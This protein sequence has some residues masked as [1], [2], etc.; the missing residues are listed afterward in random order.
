ML[1]NGLFLRNDKKYGAG[2]KITP[3]FEEGLSVIF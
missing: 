2:K 3:P 1:I